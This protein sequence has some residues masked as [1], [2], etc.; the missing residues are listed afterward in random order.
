MNTKSLVN[1]KKHKIMA[2]KELSNLIAR[3]NVLQ[4]RSG[5]THRF[6]DITLVEVDGRFFTRPY[7]FAKRGWYEAFQK[8]PNGAIKYKDIIIPI[9][10]KVPTDLDKIIPA[11]T[12]AYTDKL[13]STYQNMRAGFDGDKHDAMTIELIPKI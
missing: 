9:E 1:F 4:I 8:E 5:D 3:H 6:I 12:E 13:G 11:V 7:Q 2:N 10:A